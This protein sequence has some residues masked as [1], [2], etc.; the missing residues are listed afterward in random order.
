MNSIQDVFSVH[1]VTRDGFAFTVTSSFTV[2]ATP[3]ENDCNRMPG[4]SLFCCDTTTLSADSQLSISP[5]SY[6]FGVTIFDDDV[7]PYVFRDNT[8]FVVEHF[9]AVLGSTLHDGTS[10]NLMQ[11]GVTGG[12]VLMRFFIGNCFLQINY[13]KLIT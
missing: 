1:S 11:S 13:F 5:D 4:N 3:L 8:D 2:R 9:Q 6:S 12:F 10:Y 7:T